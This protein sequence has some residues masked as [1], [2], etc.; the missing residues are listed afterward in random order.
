[1]NSPLQK[2][3][4]YGIKKQLLC[5]AIHEIEVECRCLKCF[6]FSL[7]SVIFTSLHLE[8]YGFFSVT[9]AKDERASNK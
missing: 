3:E 5:G 8:N 4:Y 6:E 1:M 2:V 9:G 7:I